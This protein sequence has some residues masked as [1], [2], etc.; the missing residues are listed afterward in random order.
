MM[1]RFREG[2]GGPLAWAFLVVVVI[3]FVFSGVSNFLVSSDGDK[4]A[5]VGGAKIGRAEFD[6]AYQSAR[7]RYGEMYGQ[8]FN[9]EEKEQ[10]FRRNV[11]DQLITQKALAQS[12]DK[13]NFRISK[14][15]LKD[16][17]Q[18]MAAFQTDGKY[19]E[20]KA[21]M[22]LAQ[23]GYTPE[24]FSSQMEKDMVATQMLRGLADTAFSL[25]SETERFYQ[26]ENESLSGRFARVPVTAFAPTEAPADAEIDAY[27]NGHTGD[28][29]VPEKLDLQYL[30]LNASDLAGLVTVADADLESYYQEHKSEFSRAER[31]KLAHILFTVPEGADAAAEAAV[32]SQAEAVLTKAQSG[33]DFAALA[34][35]NS[36]DEIS[37]NQGGELGV[38]EKGAMDPAFDDAAFALTTAQ[39]VSS[40]V[41]TSF[42]FH[43]IKLLGIEGGEQQTLDSVREQ[44]RTAVHNQKV[45]DLFAEKEQAMNEKG[46]EASDSL[47]EAAAATGLTVKETGMFERSAPTGIAAQHAVIEAAVSDDVLNQRRNSALI[48]LGDQHS[49]MIR[50]KDYQAASTKPLA[51][52]RNQIVAVLNEQRAKAAAKAFGD[53][54]LAKLKAGEEVGTLLAEKNAN[55]QGF[56]AVTRSAAS[57]DPIVREQLFKLPRPADKPSLAGISLAGGDFLLAELQKA[58]LPALDGLD[59]AKRTQ[60]QERLSRAAGEAEYM[61][62]IKWLKA[63]VDIDYFD[64]KLKA[65]D[66]TN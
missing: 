26:L 47:D 65:P 14:N 30:E 32:R 33:E 9:T 6:Q 42:G 46:F 13:L 11:L 37:K 23:N 53:E 49:V 10:D 43:I 36:A 19:D 15:R 58:S 4:L 48:S 12:L 20:T 24:R 56:E 31:R 5:E 17:I 66:A 40:L 59:A 7:A 51:D 55:W 3:S 1:D 38:M 2:L 44:V 39:P 21:K 45:A 8:L 54:L 28:F 35:A 34:K 16:Q 18:S 41:R 64:S 60:Y 25:N 63:N 50:V 57:P 27:Y 22:L 62:Y 61:A 29:A 52:V